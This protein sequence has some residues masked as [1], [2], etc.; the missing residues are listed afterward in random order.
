MKKLTN[1]ADKPNV[2]AAVAAAASKRSRSQPKKSSEVDRADSDPVME[3][4]K[5]NKSRSTSRGVLNRFKGKKDE[6]EVRKEG[7]ELD[8]EE[9]KPEEVPTT[10][11]VA[12]AAAGT[13]IVGASGIAAAEVT[14]TGKRILRSERFVF[15][16]C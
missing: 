3:E 13:A 5:K 6:P 1:F 8:K 14:S 16:N 15:C 9:P 4:K 2:T 10:D 12:A 7:E 11:E